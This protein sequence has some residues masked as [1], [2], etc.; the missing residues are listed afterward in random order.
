RIL[1]IV[2]LAVVLVAIAVGLV[3]WIGG[4]RS[5]AQTA[6]RED[7]R[8]ST[9]G[10]RRHALGGAIVVL[11]VALALALLAAGGLLTRSFLQLTRVNPGFRAEHVLTVRTTL[12]A[13][14]Y[15]TPDRIRLFA[16][17]L[18]E[19]LRRLPGADIVG[20]A[21]YPPM[22]NFGRGASFS[23]D[24]RP[25]AAKGEEPGSWVSVVGGDYFSA[26]EIPLV[27][28]RLF[29]DADTARTP[30]VFVI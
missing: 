6:L 10:R 1:G 11:E 29:T 4:A 16:S 17:A 18:I 7:T 23:I 14:R 22:S 20:L 13:A 9:A 5:I 28:G 8:N 26:M 15:D 19:R 2:S 24:G 25:K 3:P 30:P 12:P 27:R 21:D